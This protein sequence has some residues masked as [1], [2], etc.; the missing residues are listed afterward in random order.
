MWEREPLALEPAEQG[1]PCVE[2]DE[3][4]IIGN[5]NDVIWAFGI[6]D[7][8]NKNARVFCVLNDRR[9]VTLL[10]LIKKNVNTIAPINENKEFTTRVFSDCFSSYRESDFNGMNYILHCVNHSVWF[11][12]GMFHTNTVEGLWSCLK[13]I[14]NGFSGI[15]FGLLSDLEKE[16]IDAK[17]YIDDWLCFCLFMR[18][19]ERNNFSESQSRDYLCYILLYH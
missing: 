18:E 9:K 7:R 3:T 11:G 19:I 5:A 2:I 8:S 1:Y 14:S 17:S 13:R 6:I 10:P 15:N 16:G 4:S 12:Q